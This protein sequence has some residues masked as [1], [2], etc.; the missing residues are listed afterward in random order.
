MLSRIKLRN[1][2]CFEAI[3]CEFAPGVNAIVGP[4][5][6]GKTSLLE[7]ACVLLRLQSPRVSMLARAIRHDQKSFVL[8]GYFEQRHMQFYF[9]AQRKKLALDSVEQ[10]SSRQ[11]LAIA[12]VV[13]FSN[14]D[15]ELVYGPAEQRR[16]FL[17]FVAGQIDAG[18]RKALRAYE[19]ALRSRNHLLKLPQPKWREVAAFDVPLIEAGDYLIESRSRLIEALGPPANSAQQAISGDAESLRLAYM[20]G[21][22]AHFAQALEASRADDLRLRQTTAGPH[23]DDMALVL[24]ERASE[25]ASEGQQRSMA[26]ALKL[27]QA[28][29]LQHHAGAPPLLLIDDIFGELDARRRNALMLNLPAGSQKL[30]TTTSLDW[31]EPGVE[32]AVF[33]LNHGALTTE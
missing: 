22:G 24:N 1:F 15:L 27:A 21:G 16:R 30:I 28:A 6:K 26:L 5:A 13:Y 3:E 33:R 31:L 8:D 9:S 32:A 29:V 2:R 7:A 12:R 18:Y 11:Y 20:P 19:R 14:H 23:R 17:D 10:K 25:F 4:N